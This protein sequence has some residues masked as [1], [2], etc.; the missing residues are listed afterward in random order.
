MVLDEYNRIWED[1]FN[2]AENTPFLN[3]S[4]L[5]IPF[6]DID[7]SKKPIDIYEGN[8]KISFK[9]RHKNYRKIFIQ[10]FLT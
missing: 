3:I 10:E 7:K 6:D 2:L 5:T 9:E 4:H 8:E 1:I